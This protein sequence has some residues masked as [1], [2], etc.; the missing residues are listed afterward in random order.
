MKSYRSI[1]PVPLMNVCFLTGTE[2]VR[3]R[4]ESEE[5]HFE[6]IATGDESWFQYSDPSAKMF[7]QSLTHVIPK[8]QQAIK[9]KQTMITIFFTRRK[10]SILDI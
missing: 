5:N 8:T 4:H 7:A 6:G 1:I 10:L 2:M 9:M 3:I